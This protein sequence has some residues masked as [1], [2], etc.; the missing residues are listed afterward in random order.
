MIRQQSDAIGKEAEQQAHEKVR[1]PF[2]VCASIAQAHGE[3]AKLR[4]RLLGDTRSGPLRP[5]QFRFREDSAQDFQRRQGAIGRGSRGEQIVQAEAVYLR[6][7]AIEV[8]MNFEAIL[9]A[10]HQQRRMI[11]SVKFCRSG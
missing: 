10:D 2:R 3:G 1:G 8:R 9:V 6:F 5:Q 4:R 7:R 11:E